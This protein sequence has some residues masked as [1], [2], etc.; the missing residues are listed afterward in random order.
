MRSPS[1]S[2]CLCALLLAAAGCHRRQQ[3]ENRQGLAAST[4]AST[5]GAGAPAARSAK[6]AEN[7]ACKLLTKD[8]AE[9]LLGEPV[10]A[11]PVTSTMADIG[12]VSWRCG[13]LSA[14]PKLQGPTSSTKVVTLLVKHWQDPTETR[15]AYEHAH[16]LSQTISGQ[17]PEPVAG[18]GERAYW[19]GG[20]V[21]QLN[22]LAGGDW[23]VVSGTQG[24]GLDQLAPAKAAAARILAHH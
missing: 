24:P 19:A 4:G 20:K 7:L 1:L 14:N 12:V 9:A 11:P 21:N 8:D 6:P 16:A 23:L 17:V 3:Q 18:L 13:Y 10:Q 15:S 5:A 2:L 22:V